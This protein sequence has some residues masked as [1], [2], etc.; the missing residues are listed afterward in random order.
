MLAGACGAGGPEPGALGAEARR[1][2]DGGVPGAAGAW[3]QDRSRLL[4]VRKFRVLNLRSPEH[5]SAD[6][7]ARSGVGS[8]HSHGRSCWGAGVQEEKLPSPSGGTADLA[9]G[10][11]PLP[12]PG[13]R[14][15]EG[16]T[17]F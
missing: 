17:S 7:Q 6:E 15:E 11:L 4:G 3:G 14:D 13:A 8:T 10:R 2:E 16:W 5:V 9:P 1:R 12:T